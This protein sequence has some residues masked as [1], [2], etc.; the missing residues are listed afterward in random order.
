MLVGQDWFEVTGS[1]EVASVTMTATN[2]CDLYLCAFNGASL[3]VVGFSLNIGG[4]ESWEVPIRVGN[5]GAGAGL[6]K[7]YIGVSAFTGEAAG[8]YTIT[9]KTTLS[10]ADSLAI[11]SVATIDS[12]T[13]NATIT[14][15]GF[16]NSGGSPT[17]SFSDP[18]ISVNSVTFNSST[19]LTVNY[20][21]GGGFSPPGTTD[22]TVANANGTYSGFFPGVT[23]VPVELS[24]F[25]L[26]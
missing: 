16:S 6:G 14:G 9:V 5:L 12:G 18:S 7:L 3:S 13:N 26:D 19:E 2:D 22:V 4:S 17:V 21:T 8:T 25:T 20:T 24:G 10:D 1:V 23:T 11:A 15:R